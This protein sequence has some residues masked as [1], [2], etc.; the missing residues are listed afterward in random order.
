MFELITNVCV[1]MEKV[2]V[3]LLQNGTDW[4]GCM[5]SPQVKTNIHLGNVLNYQSV[6][7]L[8]KTF[9]LRGGGD[10]GSTGGKLLITSSAK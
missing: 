2:I 3:Y 7:N 6:L 1:L 8:T 5:F 9:W 10:V 4:S